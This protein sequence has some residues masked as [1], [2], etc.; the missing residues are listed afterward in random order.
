MP[1]NRL[2]FRELLLR[3]V[4]LSTMYFQPPD[5]VH[6][7][8]PCLRYSVEGMPAMHA[9]DQPFIVSTRYSVILIDKD[10]DS[11]YV[12]R[13]AKI[14]GVRFDRFYTSDNLNHWVFSITY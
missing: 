8:Y 7:I 5:N 9:D 11:I 2:N 6:M 4:G 12:G 10:P 13:L 1:R 3:E 14:P